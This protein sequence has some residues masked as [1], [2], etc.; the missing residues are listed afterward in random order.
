MSTS[1]LSIIILS[2]CEI[3]LAMCILLLDRKKRNKH[4]R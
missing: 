4:Y 1:D 3:V 2:I